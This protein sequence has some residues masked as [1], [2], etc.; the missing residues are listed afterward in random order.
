MRVSSSSMP[1]AAGADP[2]RSLDPVQRQAADR[3]LQGLGGG[4]I[5][6]VAADVD[7]DGRRE[8]VLLW[9]LRGAAGAGHATLT[10]LAGAGRLWRDAASLALGGR[11]E[12]I[13]EVEQGGVV[14][15]A[16]RVPR[17]GGASAAPSATRLQ[18]LRFVAGRLLP[19]PE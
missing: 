15:V 1:P 11:V 8:V 16:T 19:A 17:D 9:M 10:V 7:G 13:S 12:R 6:A 5:D 2:L 14:R 18:R 4:G 3:F